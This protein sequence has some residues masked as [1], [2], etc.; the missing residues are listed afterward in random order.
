MIFSISFP[1]VCLSSIFSFLGGFFLGD[2][3]ARQEI[4]YNRQIYRNN[5]NENRTQ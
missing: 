2:F 4:F 1:I 3:E 5:I